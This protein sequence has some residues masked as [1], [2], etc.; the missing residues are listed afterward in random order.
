MSQ[1]KRTSAPASKPA[2]TA[3]AVGAHAAAAPRP[4]EPPIPTTHISRPCPPPSPKTDRRPQP[5]QQYEPWQPFSQSVHV[6]WKQILPLPRPNRQPPR[7]PASFMQ[8]RSLELAKRCTALHTVAY[9]CTAPP[10]NTTTPPSS[11]NSRNRVTELQPPAASAPAIKIAQIV[12][13][14]RGEH[15]PRTCP[16]PN[17]N[18]LL[19]RSPH[20]PYDRSKGL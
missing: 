17:P 4:A 9:R 10:Q 6:S 12:L 1:Q 19:A 18:A 13:I 11:N 14:Y 8:P 3:S 16:N 20:A 2:L 5:R 7:H 15:F